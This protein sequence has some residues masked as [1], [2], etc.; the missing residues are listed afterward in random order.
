MKNFK[1]IAS[2]A[3]SVIAVILITWLS[4]SVFDIGFAR[5]MYGDGSLSS[6]NIISVLHRV[7]VHF[8]EVNDGIVFIR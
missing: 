4:V 7:F 2:F 8:F 1:K 3:G 5:S 6:F